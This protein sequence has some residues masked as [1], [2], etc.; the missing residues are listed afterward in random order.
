MVDAP[1]LINPSQATGTKSAS[2]LSHTIILLRKLCC[3]PSVGASCW[4]LFSSGGCS[5][6]RWR[7]STR[8]CTSSSRRCRTS[9]RSWTR[10]RCVRDFM[11]NS[12]IFVLMSAVFVQPVSEWFQGGCCARTVC[13]GS[14]QAGQAG[15]SLPTLS[16]VSLRLF[17]GQSGTVYVQPVSKSFQ[18]GC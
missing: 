9:T 3:P 14:G 1:T 2:V 10:H 16:P 5:T 15:S 4:Q 17:V 8:W 12:V 11:F 7:R 6:T 18:G 13:C